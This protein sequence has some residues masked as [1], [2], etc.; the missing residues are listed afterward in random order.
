MSFT[1]Q[2]PPFANYNSDSDL[3]TFLQSTPPPLC[4]LTSQKSLKDQ[5]TEVTNQIE[6][7]E[8]SMSE[9]DNFVD[10]VCQIDIKK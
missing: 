10:S 2:K 6:M 4:S 5:V 8:T 3:E 9:F 1:L 7:F